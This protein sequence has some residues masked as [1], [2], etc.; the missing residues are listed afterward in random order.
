[1]EECGVRYPPSSYK[2]A[3]IFWHTLY[4]DARTRCTPAI[5]PVITLGLPF[6]SVPKSDLPPSSST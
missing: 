1:M 2:M 5:L 6:L 3:S 4:P